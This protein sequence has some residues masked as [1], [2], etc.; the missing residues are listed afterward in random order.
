[1]IV[2][3]PK[4]KGKENLNKDQASLREKGG[5]LCPP[6]PP[7]A[8]LRNKGRQKTRQNQIHNHKGRL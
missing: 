5:G 4:E 7:R 6:T 2:D 8:L 1:M 3:N